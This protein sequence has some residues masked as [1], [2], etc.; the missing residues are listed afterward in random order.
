MKSGLMVSWAERCFSSAAA[1]L[2]VLL[3][4]L[5]VAGSAQAAV[6]IIA[7]DG[8]GAGNV[9]SVPA[10]IN[11]GS[12]TDCYELILDALTLTATPET[13]STFVGWSGACSGTGLCVV[14]NTK[15]DQTVTATF[16]GPTLFVS[17]A[18]TGT[19]V[20][21]SVPTGIVCPGSCSKSFNRVTQN[22]AATVV[23]LTATPAADSTFTGWSGVDGVACG[24]AATCSVTMNTARNVTATFTGAKV[25]NFVIYVG[26]LGG[27]LGR[28][29]SSPEPATPVP[30]GAAYIDCG[31]RCRDTFPLG[32]PVILKAVAA[33]GATF[34]GWTGCTNNASASQDCVVYNTDSTVILPPVT[35]SFTNAATSVRTLWVTKQGAGTG[36]ITSISSPTVTGQ[37]EVNCG[38]TCTVDYNPDATV[39]LT[40]S[41]GAPAFA[42]WR[43]A[44]VG[45]RTTCTVTM[46]TSKSVIATFVPSVTTS[47]L[48][49]GRGVVTSQPTGINCGSSC[50]A[51]F[52]SASSAILTATPNTG[53]VFAGWA[54]P[55]TGTAACTV[56]TSVTQNV[57]A[58]FSL[59]NPSVSIPS[60]PV[61]AAAKPGPANA[62]ISFA[63]PASESS[64]PV[65]R[66]DASCQASGLSR[67]TASGTASP[68][69]V[70][71]LLPRTAYACSVIAVNNVGAS[72]A[73]ASLTVTPLSNDISSILLL[74]LD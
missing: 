34:T 52:A 41:P 10:G 48:G 68:I 28:V 58:V 71:Q 55:C 57:T 40:A 54:G 61:I 30:S 60:A 7:T 67:M 46:E 35:A 12:G 18:G 62:V 5:L 4:T 22:V 32:A 21:T 6:L 73:S 17:E 66:F 15:G 19:G 59:A 16:S 27:G 69:V 29:Y 38:G 24:V 23:T 43:G 8:T 36:S 9:L 72:P 47:L 74:L 33:T 49:T 31:S 3:L 45:T 56:G 65:I 25:I 13:G 64:S 50:S 44:C 42:G 1:R 37:K 70:R 11:C 26:K 53:S 39:T 14:T 2:A 51:V 20:V 63:P